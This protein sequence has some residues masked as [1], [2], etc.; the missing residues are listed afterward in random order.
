LRAR[1]QVRAAAA[2]RSKLCGVLRAGPGRRD[3]ACRRYDYN[4]H[5]RRTACGAAGGRQDN[6]YLLRCHLQLKTIILPR[7]ARDKDTQGKHSKREMR[8]LTGAATENHRTIWS[9]NRA[10]SKE[11]FTLDEE[12]F[13]HSA[14]PRASVAAASGAA[15]AKKSR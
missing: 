11:E 6:A 4:R 8:F 1:G 5:A 13:W 12:R 7:Q 3:A 10:Q 9:Y 2:G 15:D 14:G